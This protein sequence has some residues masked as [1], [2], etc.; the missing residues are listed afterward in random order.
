[1]KFVLIFLGG[2]IGSVL[3]FYLGK[4]ITST[5][6]NVFPLATISVNVFSSFILGLLAAY[7]A[8]K[9]NS[10]NLWLFLAVGFCGGFSTFSAFSLEVFQF[11][12]SGMIVMA[13]L[14]ILL[15]VVACVTALWI[16]YSI[17]SK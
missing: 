8:S 5:S 2:G 9:L 17:V 13:L 10:D 12:K 4:I 15:S 16:G 1:M 3:R 7:T 11:I 14:N 6:S